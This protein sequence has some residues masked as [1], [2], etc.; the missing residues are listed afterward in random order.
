M[1]FDAV[2]VPCRSS[3]HEECSTAFAG[4]LP[5]GEHCCCGGLYD[6]LEHVKLLV[7]Q[8]WGEG[9]EPSSRK[10]TLAAVATPLLKR[11]NSGYIHPEAWPSERDIGS[12][13]DVASTGRKRVAEMYPITPG[14]VCDWARLGNCGGGVEPV[15]GC[16]GN[17]ATDLHHGPDKN[18][19]NN[20]KGSRG[21]GEQENVHALCSFCHNDW[22]AKNNRYYPEYDRQ[23]QQ[24]QPWL[25]LSDEPWGPHAPQPA[26]IEELLE[27][28]RQRTEKDK[29]NGQKRGRNSK[30]RTDVD[31]TIRNE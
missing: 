1:N 3:R 21:V 30:P 18:T 13:D 5:E 28:E 14:Q 19:L 22:H 23:E 16:L 15:M 4:E 17:P 26:S 9:G 24:A 27:N 31:T 25:P 6:R 11:G 8:Q 29:S 20:E 10:K 12:F 2:C 7:E